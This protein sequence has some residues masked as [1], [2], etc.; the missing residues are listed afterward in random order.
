MNLI[1]LSLIALVSVLIC[2]VEADVLTC[3][4][5]ASSETSVGS[6]WGE[7]QECVAGVKYFCD[8][9]SYSSAT[10]TAGAKKGVKVLDNCSDISEY[11]A[12]ATFG[13]D[14]KYN[15]RHAA[16]FI[17]CDSQAKTIEVFDQWAP[18][19]NPK[20]PAQPWHSRTIWNT[21]GGDSDNPNKFYVVNY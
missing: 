17:S 5:S 20:R 7:S 4:S 15:S 3:S 8:W 11:T 16:V 6:F 18:R 13:S 2:C 21:N 10:F 14:G 19:T 12:I 1:S 9:A